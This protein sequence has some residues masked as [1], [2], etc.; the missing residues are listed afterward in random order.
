L[1]ALLPPPPVLVV[2]ALLTPVTCDIIDVA[3]QLPLSWLRPASSRAAET[4]SRGSA[5]ASTSVSITTNQRSD[6]F[7]F[8]KNR[9]LDRSTLK[10]QFVLS[11]DFSLAIPLLWQRV[12]FRSQTDIYQSAAKPFVTSNYLPRHAHL[13]TSWYKGQL[14]TIL[15]FL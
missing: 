4:C 9:I 5:S 3:W 2:R 6:V 8:F 15:R 1:L 13:F 14:C 7:Y 10:R 12:T 11:R